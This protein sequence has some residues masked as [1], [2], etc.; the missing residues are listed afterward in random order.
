MVL[1][2]D[3]KL[4]ENRLALLIEISG[5]FGSFADFSKLST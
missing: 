4:R 5:L 2:D 3:Q 1:A